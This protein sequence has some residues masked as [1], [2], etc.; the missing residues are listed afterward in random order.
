MKYIFTLCSLFLL[1]SI[2]AQIVYV[3]N[4]D[5][6]YPFPSSNIT[7][8]YTLDINNDGELDFEI[9]FDYS[10]FS[11]CNASG[12]NIPFI[13]DIYLKGKTNSFGTNK[14]NSSVPNQN[15]L[16]CLN[17]TLSNLSTFN[18][19]AFIKNY[20]TIIPFGNHKLGFKLILPNPLNGALGNKYGYI[21][22]SFT[23]DG[24]IIVHGWYYS[25]MFS[26]PIIAN[27][28]PD[29]PANSSCINYDTVTVYDTLQVYDTITTMVYDTNYVTIYDTITSY[30]TVYDTLTTYITEFDTV[31]VSV[32]DTLIINTALSL[33]PPNNEN[34]ILIYPNP[35]HDHLTIDHG[36][37]AL[38]NGY[39]IKISNIAG[40]VL[41]WNQINQ[42][43][44][45][46]DI[47]NWPQDSMYFITLIDSQGNT[48]TTRKLVFQ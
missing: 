30:Q 46:L 35:A 32:T 21:D 44:T 25:D 13:H 45:Y 26:Q 19:Y 11:E 41:Y 5:G 42:Q 24:D 20:C 2:N 39:S 40:Q 14:L 8:N 9:I 18:Q 36:N 28:L 17:D 38:M 34:T 10:A 6:V 27:S 47:S 4:Y 15:A 31:L 23:S 43:Q 22:Y 48:L 3:D 33:P 37:Y 12:I 16:D 29:Y 1:S 7:T